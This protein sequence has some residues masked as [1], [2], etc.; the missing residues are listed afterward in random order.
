MAG[1]PVEVAW[2]DRRTF[3]VKEGGRS[4]VTEVVRLLGS[5][6]AAALELAQG[7]AHTLGLKEGELPL[8]E[9]PYGVHLFH[10]WGDLYGAWLAA[11]LEE[12]YAGDDEPFVFS[13]DAC[14]LRLPLAISALPPWSDALAASTLKQLEPGFERLLELGRFHPLL[15]PKVAFRGVMAGCDVARFETLYR[16]ATPIR[17]TVELSEA[18]RELL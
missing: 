12:V 14:T 4:A 16:A 15:P 7:V 5:K 17:P 11:M 1:R 13:A 3:A 9:D 8:L 2:S 10:F 6:Q 18:L